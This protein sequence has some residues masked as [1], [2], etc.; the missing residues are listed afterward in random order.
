MS[1]LLADRIRHNADRLRLSHIAQSAEQLLS[2]AEGE[3]MGYIEF[4]DLALEE[5]VGL[6]EGRRFRNA[7]KLSGL[8]HH[9]GLD[10]FD[11]AFQPDLDA[12]KVRDLAAL[13]FVE[14]KANVL[15]PRPARGRQDH[16]CG[17]P[18]HRRLP[19]RLL[20]LPAPPWTTW[21]ETSARPSRPAGSPRSCRPTSNPLSWW[22]TK[23]GISRWPAPTPTWPSSSS[24]A[25]MSAARSCSPPTRRSANGAASS[26]TTC[27]PPRSWTGCCT[28]AT[29]SPSTVPATGSRTDSSPRTEVVPWSD[30]A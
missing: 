10:A 17:R 7:L 3:Q 21:S 29:S 18:S 4:V 9:M 25:G 19:G 12:R 24:P 5:E 23:W 13:E 30:L 6:R 1:E 20:G 16:A 2:R 28:T 26:A 8:P 11:F 15:A 22:S 14:Q 27:S